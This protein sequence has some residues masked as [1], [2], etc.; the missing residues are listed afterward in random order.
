MA[1]ITHTQL[2]QLGHTLGY[3]FMGN[4][5]ICAGFT[6]AWRQAVVAN[7]EVVFFRRLHLISESLSDHPQSGVKDIANNITSL[8]HQLMTDRAFLPTPVQYELL[9]IPA[10]FETMSGYQIP[11]KNAKLFNGKYVSQHEHETIFPFFKSKLLEHTNIFILLN[12]HLALTKIELKKFLESL[13]K[14]LRTTQRHLPIKIGNGK[15]AIG[16]RYDQ[17]KACWIYIDINDFRRFPALRNYYRE[18]DTRSL[19]DGIFRSLENANSTH[20]FLN[21]NI[22]D[23]VADIELA[24]Q[25]NH[26]IHPQ[27][28][29][30]KHALLY[31][32]KRHSLLYFASK[33]GQT[34]SVDTL[35]KLGANVNLASTD[36][37]LSPLFISCQS[38]YTDVVQR[39][40]LCDNIIVNQASHLGTTPLTVACKLGHVDIVRLLLRHPKINLNIPNNNGYTPLF[41]AAMKKTANHEAIISML[42]THGAN[43]T[44]KNNL[45]RT[46]LDELFI[47]HQVDNKKTIVTAMIKHANQNSIRFDRIMSPQTFQLALEW[48][49]ESAPD[50]FT[51]LTRK[52]PT[53][54]KTKNIKKRITKLFHKSTRQTDSHHGLFSNPLNNPNDSELS[55]HSQLR[56]YHHKP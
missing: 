36:L 33:T 28:I 44:Y 4:S 29:R 50:I 18:L 39:L 40:L 1:K 54:L 10:F 42:L 55:T 30:A 51:I 35:I 3:L 21:I 53:K 19:V 5:G 22:I 43:L 31:D 27:S 2:L 56:P 6:N 17:Q 13:K 9:E 20:L 41:L 37:G 7:E 12:S 25:F 15:H 47:T 23:T 16:L 8:R 45:N 32:D 26:L 49:K 11:H 34:E 48:S 52:R 24:N 46:V 14:I 38:G